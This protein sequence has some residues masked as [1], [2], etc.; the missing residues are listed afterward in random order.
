MAPKIFLTG[1][2]GYIG[3]DAF[4]AIHSAHPDYEYTLLVRNEDRGKVVKAKYP[5][6]KLVYG[7]LDDADVIEQAAAA[8]DVVVHAAD[9]ADDSPSAK[10]IAK[11]LEAGHSAEKPG[12]W[13]HVSG[14][15]IL[16]WYD[17][18]NKRYGQG[19]LPDQSYNDLTDIDRVVSLPDEALHRDVDKIVLA[20]NASPAIRTAIVAPPT[21][22]GPGRGPANTRSQQVYALAKFLLQ[23]GFAPI[24]GTGTTEWDNIHVHDVSALLLAL[25]DAALDPALASN[26]EVFGPK[27]YFFAEH[28]VHVWGDVARSVADAAYRLGYMGEPK[29]EALS[30]EAW[31]KKRGSDQPSTW[32]C[33]S[34]SVAARARKF[35]GWTPKGRS[36]EDEIPDIVKGEAELLGI[37]PTAETH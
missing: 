17:L 37:K 16:Q 22:Y 18:V 21:I 1:A 28:G 14:T 9:S 25:V 2:T 20:A 10:A 24:I 30:M 34:K 29:T 12:H 36:L 5:N 32:G 33:N 26:P 13:I 11:G 7:S 15:G 27:A 23:E 6:V 4:Y 31:M 8:A 19:P 35:L 3:G